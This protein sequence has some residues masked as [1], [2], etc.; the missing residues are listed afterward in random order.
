ME[1]MVEIVC[2]STPYLILLLYVCNLRAKSSQTKI[3]A[4]N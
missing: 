1:E 2:F 4:L 3:P